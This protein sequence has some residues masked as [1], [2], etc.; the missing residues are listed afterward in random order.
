VLASAGTFTI[1][2]YALLALPS[3][4]GTVLS[5]LPGDMGPAAS[6]L[7]SASGL[8]LGIAEVTIVHVSGDGPSLYGFQLQ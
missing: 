1:P 7:F 5:F 2:A 4:P 8:D 6:T 3:T